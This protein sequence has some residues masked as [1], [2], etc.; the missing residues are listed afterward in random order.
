[1]YT[2]THNAPSLHMTKWVNMAQIEKDF[3]KWWDSYL[4]T[5]LAE[6]TPRKKKTIIIIFQLQI[7]QNDDE[8]TTSWK[9]QTYGSIHYSTM[10]FSILLLS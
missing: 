4:E 1:M 10:V 9:Y 2:Q 6:W 5:E 8:E 3:T 7:K